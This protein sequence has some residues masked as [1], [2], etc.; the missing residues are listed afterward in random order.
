[1]EI[2]V[3]EIM[4]RIKSGLIESMDTE[5]VI[6]LL[7]NEILQRRC[8]CDIPTLEEVE[9]SLR[10]QKEQQS[11]EY[12]RQHASLKY[13][14]EIENKN[15]LINFTK[16]VIRKLIFFCVQ[17]IINEQS[18]NN[19]KLLQIVVFQKE[20]INKLESEVNQLK[21]YRDKKSDTI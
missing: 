16:R 19:E 17:P 21:E 13:Y 2:N 1:M 3:E 10:C 5:E 4:K 11:I 15:K 6:G 7:S 18:E 14:H 9:S 8:E 12:L 20:Q